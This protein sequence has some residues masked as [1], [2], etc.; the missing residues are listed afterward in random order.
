MVMQPV[1]QS[2]VMQPNENRS[3]HLGGQ[4]TADS[5][6]S[7]RDASQINDK[8][9]RYGTMSGFS[10]SGIRPGSSEN[11]SANQ[12]S[13]SQSFGSSK[14]W[15]ESIWGN[16]ALSTGFRS[17]LATR[18]SSNSRDVLASSAGARNKTGGLPSANTLMASGRDLIEGKTGSS[19][20]VDSS[21]SETD[22]WRVRPLA[23]AKRDE[24]SARLGPQLKTAENVFSQQRSNSNAGLS[25]FPGSMSAYA[26]RPAPINLNAV[27]VS[28]PQYNTFDTPMSS[29]G[30]ELPP[31]VFT[32]FDRPTKPTV[33]QP[34]DSAIGAWTD[35]PTMDSPPDERKGLAS[36]RHTS[37]SSGPVSRNGS[38]PPS[39]HS[40]IQPPWPARADFYQTPQTMVDAV[41][42]AS[43]SS[44]SRP[45]YS[46]VDRS[47]ASLAQLMPQFGE[48]SVNGDNSSPVFQRQGSFGNSNVNYVPGYNTSALNRNGSFD[49]TGNT[50]QS[51][52]I[53]DIERTYPGTVH[54]GFLAPSNADPENMQL[55]GAFA[56]ERAY[57]NGNVRT[58]RQTG[59]YQVPPSYLRSFDHTRG[60]QLLNGFPNIPNGS[61]HG[62][63]TDQQLQAQQMQ[64]AQ[65]WYDPRLLNNQLR[66]QYSNMYPFA[67]PNI[68]GPSNIHGYPPISQGVPNRSLSIVDASKARE[69]E[70]GQTLRSAFL[71]EFKNNNKTN[72]RYELKDIYEHV[73]EFSGDQHGSRFIQQKLETATGEEKERIFRE[74]QPNAFQLMQDVFGNYVIQKFFEHGDQI[75]KKVLA[76]KMRGK[77]LEL[78]LQMY[79]CRVVQKALEHILND[80]QAVLIRELEQHV[81]KCVKDQNGNH[82]IQKA[83]ERCEAKDIA[84][85]LQSFTGQVQHLS[86]H[87]YGCRVIQRCLEH[88]EM[89]SKQA[90]M[91]ELHEGMAGLIGD[92]F[93]NYVVQH[94]VEHG[95]EAD[96]QK[97]L[98]LVSK[99]L[100]GYSKHKFAS[101]VV[102]KCLNFASDEWR[103][104]VV[105]IL[106]RG[107]RREGESMLIC[108]VKD[109]FG[110]YVIQKL[111]D[112]LS[113]EHYVYFIDFLQ[114][115]MV[116][117]R[118]AGGGKQLVSIEKKMHRLGSP[119]Y[120]HGHVTASSGSRSISTA[121]TPSLSVQNSSVA[122]VNG[123]ATEG[124]SSSRKGSI[125]GSE[126]GE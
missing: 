92:N 86:I 50:F 81:I 5:L 20:L 66:S 105:E 71:E 77:V 14:G 29:L 24:S 102:E 58:T 67:Y 17:S 112:V 87:T 48:I 108:L 124:A 8:H 19:A 80:Q 70:P 3:Q 60:L 16:G 114:P 52:E 101:N 34:A 82:V 69:L 125:P 103:R 15:P 37:L 79:G 61:A 9:N 47:D 13:K 98:D 111:L 30:N 104:E 43:F 25:N 84:F 65:Y 11:A 36:S 85:I 97:V 28:K 2:L 32:K 117:A 63:Y 116:K 33:S 121:T 122:S 89:S 72:K 27:N 118:R 106:V 76:N 21:I 95:G 91:A 123:D 57:P 46:H 35:M 88:C 56:G 59:H 68:Q 115:E 75:Q 74:I 22:D 39:R 73:V 96:K 31:A 41:R 10:T 45:D 55:R 7:H 38:L 44:S 4:N 113:C 78:S 93:G 99:G 18:D 119:G 42:S 53:E 110:N 49:R 120:V 6:T 1:P 23:A 12:L 94:V 107:S 40:D 51:D 26:Y 126:R 90:I 100:E 109:N 54:N 83:I 64:E 62:I